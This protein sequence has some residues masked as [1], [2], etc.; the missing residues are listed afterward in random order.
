MNARVIFSKD[1][2][3]K[4]NKPLSSFE[5]G[6]LR[7]AKIEEL[8]TSGRLSNIKNR[9]QLCLAVGMTEE[10]AK[11][12]GPAYV[13]NLVRR[14]NLKETMMGLEDGKMT[15]AYTIIKA[16]LFGKRK[17]RSRK[18]REAIPDYPKQT[19]FLNVSDTTSSQVYEAKQLAA[20]AKVL[21]KARLSIKY[22]KTEIFVE[23]GTPVEYVVD[24]LWNINQR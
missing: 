20:E 3:E 9:Q 23:E 15:F 8:N 14:K 19:Q 17:R 11:L 2:Q 24:L 5:V 12:S 21:S 10:Q 18:T 7:W 1:F 22:G 16:P 4:M 6:K 13:S